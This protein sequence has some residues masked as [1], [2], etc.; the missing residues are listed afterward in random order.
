MELVFLILAGGGLLLLGGEFL[1]RG[2]VSLAQ[3]LGLSPLLIG[4]T[5]VA[6]GTSAPE[7]VTSVQAALAGA[8]SLAVGNVVGSNIANILLVLGVCALLHPIPIDRSSVARD[9]TALLL[10][11]LVTVGVMLT[12]SFERW[13][14]ILYLLALAGYVAFAYYREKGGQDSTT[15]D[16]HLQEV[17]E[18]AGKPKPLPLSILFIAIG[19]AGLMFGADWLVEGAVGLALQLGMSEAV[20]GATIV[21]IG[22][23]LPELVASVTASLRGHLALAF[24]NVVGSCLMNLLGVLAATAI[25][26]PIPIPD[27]V[28]DLDI[29]VMTLATLALLFFASTGHR[30]IRGEGAILLILY[31]AYLGTLLAWPAGPQV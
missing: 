3:R 12:G 7:V 24:G 26:R 15:A 21:A 19:L 20:I 27:S 14:G 1:V 10:A 29:W 5:V 8:P 9:G 30:M 22:T 16:L 31:V 2:A 18:V 11:T 23:S 17:E 13:V 28:L 6:L 4:L 25:A